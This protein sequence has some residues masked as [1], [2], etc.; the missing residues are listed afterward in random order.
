LG[1]RKV[2][3]NLLFNAIS[4]YPRP[5][6][7]LNNKSQQRQE[8]QPHALSRLDAAVNAG[9]QLAAA[10][11]PLCGEPMYGLAFAV[12]SILDE[13]SSG[14]GEELSQLGGQMI[15]AMRE[16]CRLAFL[17]WSP[18]LMLAMYNCEI[19]TTGT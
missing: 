9:F 10:A 7:I 6:W 8:E 13:V 2:G 17:K 15:V 18:R 14:M 1:P 11:G 4:D 19:Q 16:A 5:P 12:E 3:V